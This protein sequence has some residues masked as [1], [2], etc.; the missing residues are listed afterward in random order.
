MKFLVQFEPGPGTRWMETPEEIAAAMRLS[1][2][3]F[4]RCSTSGEIPAVHVIPDEQPDVP[5]EPCAACGAPAFGDYSIEDDGGNEVAICTK[6]GGE[7]GPTVLELQ[8]AIA[9]RKERA[10]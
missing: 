6:C 10:E 4:A 7:D 2:E 3:A 9:E 1:L 8:A 5:S